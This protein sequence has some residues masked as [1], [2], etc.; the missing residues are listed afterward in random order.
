MKKVLK[1]ALGVILASTTLA[2]AGTLDKIAE[3]G[4]IVIGVKNDYRPWGYLDAEGNPVGLEIDLARDIAERLGVE[5]ELVPVVASNRMEFLQ[6][7]RIDLI[8]AT[9]GD[10]PQR[11]TVVGMV[12]PNYYA[13]GANVLT[14]KAN[15]LKE[16]PDLEGK[17]LC[18]IQ[19]S[20]YLREISQK[21]KA[22]IVAFA[23]VPE[24][25]AALTNGSCVGLVYDNTWVESQLMT[26]A[27]W[28]DY[29]MPFATEQLQPWAI[30]VP[31]AELDEAYGQKISEIITDWHKTGYLIEANAAHGIADS[32]FLQEQH[33]KFR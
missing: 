24:A 7:G 5:A 25:T 3:A 28:A 20:Y 10:N 19:G 9:L 2:G 31:L 4:K 11:R 29:E 30:A 18:A 32:P 22:N 23:G 13:A 14:P 33:E 1:I 21:Y 26:E 17:D 8:I 16:W 15:G 27:V 12:E 6:Q